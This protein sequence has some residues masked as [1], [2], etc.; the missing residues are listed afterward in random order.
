[1]KTESEIKEIL[2]NYKDLFEYNNTINRVA[3][4]AVISILED[5]LE[6]NS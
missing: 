1:M 2:D 5:I 6:I 4:S 3:V